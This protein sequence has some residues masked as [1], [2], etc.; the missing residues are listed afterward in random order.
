MLIQEQKRSKGKT[1]GGLSTQ[2]RPHRAMVQGGIQL[3]PLPKPALRSACSGSDPALARRKAV[4][5]ARNRIRSLLPR[6]EQ[7]FAAG[8]ASAHSKRVSLPSLRLTLFTF[9]Q[10][11][12]T[13]C[14]NIPRASEGEGESAGARGEGPGGSQM[15]LFLLKKEGGVCEEPFGAG[16]LAA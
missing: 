7:R 4:Q 10:I 3:E 6:K 5:R 9:L 2:I 11:V 12:S 13:F 15:A 14:T 8:A 16:A 1:A